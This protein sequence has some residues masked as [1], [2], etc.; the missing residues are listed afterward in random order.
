MSAI[1]RDAFKVR[2]LLNFINSINTNSLYLG[3]GRPQFW[4]VTSGVDTL[5]A[6]ENASYTAGLDWEDMT[7]L[8]KISSSDVAAGI[9]K[10]FWQANVKYDTYRH[11]WGVANRPS[12]YPTTVYNGP[13]YSPTTPSS[14]SDV[15]C[16]VVT[17]N[18]SIYLCIKHPIIDGV[19]QPSLYSPETGVAVGTN[20]TV[21]KTADGYY[22]KF[23]AGTSSADI[24]KFSSKYYTPISTLTV[25]PAPADPY[26]PQW[27]AQGHSYTLKGGIYTINVLSGGTG[28]NGGVAGT[29]VVTVAETDAQFKVKGDGINLEYTVTYGASGSITDIEITNPGTGYTHAT[30]TAVGGTGASFDIV[31]TPLTGLGCNPVLD[32]VARYLLADVTLTGAEGSG[33]FTTSNDFRKICLVY[34]PFSFNTTTVATS[35]TLDATL[36]LNVGAG[37]A[38]GAYPIDGIVTGATNGAKARVVDYNS[39]TGILRVIRTSSENANQLGANNDFQVG[40][41]LTSTGTGNSVISA[42]TTPEVQKYSGDILY[43]EYRQP[44]MRNELQTEDVKIIVRF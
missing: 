2:T 34:N 17:A 19:V 43:S 6:P 32:L 35:S 40:E 28:Y 31:F 9:Y 21:V 44:I 5:P 13:N 25:A 15:K 38:V 10:E 30:I 23:I 8:K 22:W 7:A 41:A 39:T 3:I 14:I 24:V 18:Y 11:D 26:L 20:T 12:F 36:S 1:I 42:I 33:D 27:E 4:D 16:Y 37:L 29:R